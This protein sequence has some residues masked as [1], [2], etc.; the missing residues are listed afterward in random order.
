MSTIGEYAFYNCYNL[1]SVELPQSVAEIKNYT[2]AYCSKLA[3]VSFPDE[4]K[5]IGVAAFDYCSSIKTVAMPN[6]VERVGM[7][8][9]RYCRDLESVLISENIDSINHSTFVACDNLRNVVI[10]NNV[11]YIGQAAFGLCL[12]METLVI[13]K[14]VKTIDGNA[15]NQCLALSQIDCYATTPPKTRNKPFYKVNTTACKLSVP[16]GSKAAYQAADVWKDFNLIS[17][18]EE[19]T[20]IE[21]LETSST[22]VWPTNIYDMNGRLVRENAH[23]ADG[24]TGGVYIINGRKVVIGD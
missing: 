22:S 8:A 23:S 2:F 6:S 14:C 12:S 20:S 21:E 15:F 24:L 17:E 4:L 10:P 1:T 5:V 13:G 19:L 18:K 3:S 11:T 16:I 7:S 9:F